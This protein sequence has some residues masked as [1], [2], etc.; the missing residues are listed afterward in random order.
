MAGLTAAAIAAVGFLAY[1]ASANVPANLSKPKTPSA[2][3]AGSAGAPAQKRRNPLT[4]PAESGKGLRVV[5][6]LGDRRVWLVN[7]K[8]Q[9]TRTFPVMPSK[10]SPPPGSYLVTSRSG[11]VTGSDGVRIEHV[12]RFTSVNDVVIGFSSAVDGSLSSPD[13]TLKTG[14][15]RMKRADGN[16]MWSFATVNT[17]I[18]VVP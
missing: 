3:P 16:A 17:K 2:S 15:V 6:G 13:P 8:D 11:A 18:V 1:Q 14:G 5:Y 10:I 9:A 4:L 7:E 12:V